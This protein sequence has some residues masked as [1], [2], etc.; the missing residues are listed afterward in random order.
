MPTEVVR[1]MVNRMLVEWT[2]P[3]S[4]EGDM[5]ECWLNFLDHWHH[6]D[7]VRLVTML[8]EHGIRISSES[9]DLYLEFE[10]EEAALFY[11]MKWS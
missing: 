6:T 8:Q 9:N 2:D 5:A 4:G 1:V 11:K 10:T 3:D 7:G